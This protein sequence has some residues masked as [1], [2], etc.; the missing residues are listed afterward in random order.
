MV[1]KCHTYMNS[2]DFEDEYEPFYDFSGTYEE[3]FVGKKL[4]DFDLTEETVAK[5]H[6]NL[7]RK[8]ETIEE[9]REEPREEEDWEDIDAEDANPSQSEFTIVSE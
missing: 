2:D 5:A 6:P 1:D 7:V 3:G 8:S 9:V 4:D